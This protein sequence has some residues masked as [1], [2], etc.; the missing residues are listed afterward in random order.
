MSHALQFTQNVSNGVAKPCRAL[1]FEMDELCVS[2]I[3]ID[4]NNCLEDQKIRF[5]PI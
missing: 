3:F 2:G 1:T 5:F 4:L